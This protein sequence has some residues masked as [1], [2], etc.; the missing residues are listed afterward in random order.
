MHAENSTAG[1]IITVSV[2]GPLRSVSSASSN[3]VVIASNFSTDGFTSSNSGAGKLIALG[4]LTPATNITNSLCA[5]INS[6]SQ[7]PCG[8]ML[9]LSSIL[10]DTAFF[11]LDTVT[12]SLASQ[13]SALRLPPMI[14]ITQME[15]L[16]QARLQSAIC[17]AAK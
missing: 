11:S 16:H 5:S 8:R 6:A 15:V 1:A 10:S 9:D 2:G 12:I 17:Q 13:T 3:D 7:P 14:I 4:I